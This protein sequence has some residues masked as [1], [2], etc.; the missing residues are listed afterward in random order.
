MDSKPAYAPP[1]V[2]APGHTFGTVTEQ[3]AA[4]VL[5]RRHPY[6]W[7]FGLAIGFMLSMVLLM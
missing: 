2:I 3:V 7:F 1:P 4:I 6:S 5:T